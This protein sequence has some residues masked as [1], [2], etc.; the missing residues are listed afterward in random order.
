MIEILDHPR[1]APQASM[2]CAPYQD[3]FGLAQLIVLLVGSSQVDV[4]NETLDVH[5]WFKRGRAIKRT[6]QV[7]KGQL[8]EQT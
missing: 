8:D 6:F 4:R 3:R 2:P 7:P 1:A 5:G